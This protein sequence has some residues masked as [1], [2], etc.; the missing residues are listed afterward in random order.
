[1]DKYYIGVDIGGTSAKVCMF[2]SEKDDIVRT[3]SVPTL[4]SSDEMIV[5]NRI[6]ESISKECGAYSIDIKELAGIGIGVPGPVTEEGVVLKCANLGWDIVDLRGIISRLTGIDNVRVGNDAN[7]AALGEVWRG[8]GKEYSSIVMVTLGTGVG[9]GIIINE[10]IHTG[11]AGA[12]GEIGHLTVNAD[13]TDYCGCGARGC[14]EQY[15]SATGVVRLAKKTFP[16][17]YNKDDITAKDIFDDAKAGNDKALVIVDMFAK[18]LGIAL[19]GVAKVTAPEAFIIG[20]GVAAAGSIIIDNVR[21]YYDEYSL[22]ALK[23]VPIILASLGNSA[24]VYGSVRMV[25]R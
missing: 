17:V 24:G 1:M 8:S 20:G 5:I 2:S 3:W 16:E 15:A 25:K 13:E 22:Y 18:Y 14:L 23:N 11:Y 9:G 6:I 10:D 12:A 19:A 7:V 4:K 21:K